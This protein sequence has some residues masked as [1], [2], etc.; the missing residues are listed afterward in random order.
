MN[1][2]IFIFTSVFILLA[3]LLFNIAFDLV[4]DKSFLYFFVFIYIFFIAHFFNII[5]KDFH[6][7]KFDLWWINIVKYSLFLSY[8]FLCINFLDYSIVWE[9]IVWYLLFCMLFFIDNRLSFFIAL[10]LLGFVPVYLLIWESAKAE[11]LSIYSYYFLIIWV[12]ISIFEN[13]IRRITH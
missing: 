10:S 4:I 6:I 9:L 5:K 3:L 8:I 13:I 2:N 7:Y 11:N 12:V 1:K